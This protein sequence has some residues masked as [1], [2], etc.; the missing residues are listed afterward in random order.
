MISY[1]PPWLAG[2]QSLSL[3]VPFF[4][5]VCLLFCVCVCVCACLHTQVQVHVCRFTY[6]G[7]HVE[8]R[9]QP[10]ASVFSLF[11]SS[12]VI[13]PS[14]RMSFKRFSASIPSSS[15]C[16]YVCM[17]PGNPNLS[18]C[19]RDKNFTYC[20]SLQPQISPVQMKNKSQWGRVQSNKSI[21]TVL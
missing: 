20:V 19:F 6:H 4:I 12:T 5:Y 18:S 17:S 11:L 16:I 15:E 13:Q 3:C 21:E 10:P 8:I 7:P 2:W 14:W 9:G 1:L